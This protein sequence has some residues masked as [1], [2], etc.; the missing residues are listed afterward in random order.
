M[1]LSGC[2]RGSVYVAW[3]NHGPKAQ[4]D[5]MIARFN[6]D[7]QIQGSRLISH[8]SLDVEGARA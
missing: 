4:A 6:G 3:A 1:L 8:Y 2:K 5:V 7:G